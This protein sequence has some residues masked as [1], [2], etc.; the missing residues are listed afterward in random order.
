VVVQ[1]GFAHYGPG[2]PYGINGRWVTGGY[3]AYDYSINLEANAFSLGTFDAG[4]PLMAGVTTL[5]SN[6][7]NNVTPNAAATEVA[8][9]SLGESLVAFRPV[10][11]HTTVGVTA[12]VG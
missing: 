8:Q 7:A 6:F 10:A 1:Y 5:N 9:N 2:Q 4:H 3:N 11:G 12:Y